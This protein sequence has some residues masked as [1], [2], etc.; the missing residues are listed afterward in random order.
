[1]F[2]ENLDKSFLYGFFFYYYF[3]FFSEQIPEKKQLR[4]RRVHACLDLAICDGEILEA[5]L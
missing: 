2:C 1:M 5:G 4:K 3:S